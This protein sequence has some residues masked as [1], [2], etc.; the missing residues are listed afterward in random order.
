[1]NPPRKDKKLLVLDIDYTIFDHVSNAQ[2]GSELMRPHLHEFLTSSYDNYD[3]V[4]WSATSMKWIETK[5]NEIG[6]ATHSDYKIAFYV[7]CGAMI[8]VHTAEYGV[9]NV[10]PLKVIWD[11]FPEFYSSK[12][13]I[14]FDDLRRN[15]LM[16]PQ[17]GLKI[18]PYKN[19]HTNCTKD[20]E[21]YYLDVYLKKISKLSDLSELNH[22]HWH[23]YQ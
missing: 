19:A 14:M 15:F 12:N 11:K 4:I 10:K 5:M 13:T 7:D 20:K 1:M 3:I 6:V 2:R 21:L 8:T 9:V 18:E 22:K 23:K 17:N 16:N